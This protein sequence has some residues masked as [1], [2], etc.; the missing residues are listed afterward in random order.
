MAKF[1]VEA[2]FKV[3]G[4]ANITKSFGEISG[5]ASDVNR[6]FQRFGSD[7]STVLRNAAVAGT[8]LATALAGAAKEFGQFEKGFTE[9]VTLLDQQSLSGVVGG[10][11]TLKQ[12]VI[13]LRAESGQT[14]DTL[15]KGLF[16]IVSA[17]IPASKAIATLGTAV[18][19]A[20]AGATDTSIAVDAITTSL[21]AYGDEAGNAEQIAQKFFT[22]QKFGKTTVEELSSSIGLV[23]ANA[24][25]S[26]V[27]FNELLAS[28]SSATT[29]GIRTNAAFTGLRAAIANIQRP[30]ASAQEEAERLG[31]QFD[32]AALRS[33]GFVGL[34]K[35][36][37]SSASFTQDSLIK[38]FGSVEGLNFAQA[39][40]NNNFSTTD[41]ILG[42]LG[43]QTELQTNFNDALEA[44]QNTLSFAFE[45]LGG[46]ISALATQI[47]EQFAPALIKL[48]NSLSELLTRFQDDILSFTQ[49]VAD[50]FGGLIEF[51]FGD[52]D[53][54]EAKIRQVFAESIIPTFEFFKNSITAAIE[55]IKPFFELAIAIIDGIA[56]ALGLP[57][58]ATL[59][60]IATLLQLTG[61][62]RLLTSGF[63]LINSLLGLGATLFRAIVVPLASFVLGLFGI[64]GGTTAAAIGV[65]LLNGALKLLR[66]ALLAVPWV[67]VGALILIL[68]EQFFGLQNVIEN[69]PAIL[70]EFARIWG[71]KF[72]TMLDVFKQFGALVAQAFTLLI[73]SFVENITGIAT[74]F[75]AA[76]DAIVNLAKVW[77]Q[78]M[79]DEAN[80][81][82]DQMGIIGDAIQ[83]IFRA[84]FKA[85]VFLW[86]NTI[87]RLIDLASAG[88]DLIAGVVDSFFQKLT[89][90]IDS[91]TAAWQAFINLISVLWKNFIS[92][93][94]VQGF[95]DAANRVKE[96]F[97]GIFDFISSGIQ[98]IKDL[99]SGIV[100]FFTR[101][102]DE[103]T[104]AVQTA[105]RA[106]QKFQDQQTVNNLNRNLN[107]SGLSD[108]D[109]NRI[110]SQRLAGGGLVGGRGT[111]TSDSNIIAASKGE[112]MVRAAAV[113]K[114][115]VDA[116]RM[117][118]SGVLPM[119]RGFANGGL[120]DGLNSSLRSSGTS[121]LQAAT[122]L[123]GGGSAS[124]RP[125]ALHL[126][127][128]RFNTVIPD[129]DDAERLQRVLRKNSLA[130]ASQM[131]EYFK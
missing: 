85:I 40:A 4:L 42:S 118:N 66:I 101:I 86:D 80:K 53:A 75:K 70:T 83:F 78:N 55:F 67:A 35:D 44:Q 90:L 111:S 48:F 39:V 23:A 19:L 103:T 8:A 29:T 15:N 46:V 27:G 113:K 125:L 129:Q 9:V 81:Y 34:L 37:T 62:F 7:I 45:R 16:D 95:I 127:G 31:I 84:A 1:D 123:D 12:G 10:I 65:N 93:T 50:S 54:L 60:F 94:F 6:N 2:V 87:G 104:S 47:G 105:Q 114:L 24:A 102:K 13:D 32:A 89:G 41:K 58:A 59:I 64:G 73:Q 33:Q 25:A 22:A 5:A 110:A 122:V 121:G 96:F 79:I 82:L 14:F 88:F 72:N 98:R 28:V 11:D 74:S 20:L 68:V 56:K 119:V 100:G 21:G 61:V 26:G 107:A 112:F 38:L 120:I 51:L 69:F 71:E 30:T 57:N 63:L 92:G 106:Q 3:S 49:T 52:M 126:D 115:G 128:Q 97:G 18:D 124:G 108:D 99:F 109:I 76:F 17:G 116:L 117:I 131:P 36:I 43:N 91:I 130:K 77:V